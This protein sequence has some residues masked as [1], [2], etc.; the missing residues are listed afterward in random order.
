MAPVTVVDVWTGERAAALRAALRLTNESFAAH[1][2]TS[3]RAVAAWNASPHLVPMPEVQRALDTVLRRATPDEQSRFGLLANASGSEPGHDMVAG[4]SCIR[5]H[6]FVAGYAGADVQKLVASTDAQVV[7]EN[8][9]SRRWSAPLVHPTGDATL[10]LWSHGSTIVHIVEESEWDDITSLA[11]WRYETYPRDLA[12]VQRQIDVDLAQPYIL[13]LY[14][15][16]RTSWHSRSLP[17]LIRLICSPRI[18][19][20]ENPEVRAEPGTE[21]ALVRDGFNLP[22]KAVDFGTV[23]TALGCASWSGVSYHPLNQARA[24]RE[25]ELVDME[26]M[27]QSVWQYCS[28]IAQQVESGVDPAVSV[29]YGWSWLR[30]VRSRLLMSRP[31]ETGNHRNMREAILETADLRDMIDNAIF[32]LR[33]AA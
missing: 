19:V 3:V 22:G 18:L 6:K 31:Q 1:L 29:E 7:E 11:L 14:W 26:L 25:S 15:L 28:W 5:S 16:L 8:S 10:H 2:G 24:L 4:T 17:S 20:G 23:D 27:T 9:I 12:W 30:A 13:S 21:S 32:I 33:E